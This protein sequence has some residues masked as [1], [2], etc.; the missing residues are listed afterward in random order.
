[1]NLIIPRAYVMRRHA[2][3]EEYTTFS[4]FK[5]Y[6]LKELPF[7]TLKAITGARVE[8]IILDRNCQPRVQIH[9]A[10]SEEGVEHL[11]PDLARINAGITLVNPLQYSPA[12]KLA[13]SQSMNPKD[14]AKLLNGKGLLDTNG[15][16]SLNKKIINGG[17]ELSSLDQLGALGKIMDLFEEVDSGWYEKERSDGK[18]SRCNHIHVT[19]ARSRVYPTTLAHTRMATGNR[20]HGPF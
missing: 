8:R 3:E 20:S 12:R 17:M 10:G 6:A 5:K 1:M 2:G 18:V 13:F 7:Y 16:L 4:H 11:R 9:K 19:H 15:K 14:M